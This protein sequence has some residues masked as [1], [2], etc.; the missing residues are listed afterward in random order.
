MGTGIAG[1]AGLDPHGRR[2]GQ[3]ADAC[4]YPRPFRED[5]DDC[6]TYQGRLFVGLDLQYRP[7]RP[8]RTCRFLTVGAVAGQPGTFYARCALGD[9]EARLSWLDG[10]DRERLARLQALRQRMAEFMGPHLE[11]LWRLKGEQLRARGLSESG[12][13]GVQ[14]ALQTLSDRLAQ[15]VERFLEEQETGLAELGIPSDALLEAT[16]LSLRAFVEQPTGELT[17]VE[18]P[19]DLLRRF[20]QEVQA[21]VRPVPSLPLTETG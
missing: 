3:P 11:E 7:L 21:L 13:S 17:D 5:F 12:P 2:G 19:D 8:S 6:P 4:P 9:A 16:L 15:E 14:Q 18:L 1:P 10:L 20:P